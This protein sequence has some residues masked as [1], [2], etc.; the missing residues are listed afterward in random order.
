MSRATSLKALVGNLRFIVTWKTWA[1][2]VVFG[3]PLAAMAGAGAR[4]EGLAGAGLPASVGGLF[5]G[6]AVA[7]AL[8]RSGRL[9]AWVRPR[10]GGSS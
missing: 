5:S 6:V 7:V 2:L 8:G 9:A 4:A 3:L 10:L 1:A